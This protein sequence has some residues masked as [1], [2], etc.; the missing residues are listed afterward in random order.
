MTSTATSVAVADEM[1]PP[2]RQGRSLGCTASCTALLPR[3]FVGT[4]FGSTRR[5]TPRRPGSPPL[6]SG[7]QARSRWPFS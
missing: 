1:V 5:R 4:G 3:R 6:M 2:S 7:H